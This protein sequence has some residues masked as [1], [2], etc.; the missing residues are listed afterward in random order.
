MIIE[1]GSEM[2][3]DMSSDLLWI[4][5]IYTDSSWSSAAAGLLRCVSMEERPCVEMPNMD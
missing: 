4:S 1:I 5:C 2:C 3:I